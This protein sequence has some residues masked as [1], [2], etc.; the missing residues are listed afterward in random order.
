MGRRH[1]VELSPGL[2]NAVPPALGACQHRDGFL[3]RAGYATVYLYI[4]DALVDTSSCTCE[5]REFLQKSAG[6][7]YSGEGNPAG[8]LAGRQDHGY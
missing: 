3:E 5:G 8:R 6:T 1:I 2:V 7:D 4:R